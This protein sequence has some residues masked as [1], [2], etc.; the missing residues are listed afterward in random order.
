[1]SDPRGEMLAR[2]RA[3][4]ATARLPAPP[5]LP[6]P[7]AATA[8]VEPLVA[9]FAREASAL[10]CVVHGPIPAGEAEAAVV[11]IL[12]ELHAHRLLA[13][14]AGELPSPGLL[15]ALAEHGFQM[16]DA[17][18]PADRAGRAARLARLDSADVGLTGAL[19]GLADTGSLVL[20]SGP[21]R[22]RLAWLLPP[23]HVALLRVERLFAGLAAFLAGAREQA[24]ANANL[25]FV[26]GPSRTG[27]IELIL[28][29][30]V[31]G[32]GAVHVIL[33]R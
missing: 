17:R 21:G 29:R 28:T 14:E 18:L 7:T 4:L 10:G 19:A 2:V 13:W 23:V 3:A 31:H 16:Q 20:T 5:S 27:D 6:A 24:S 30:G 15:D 12:R 25:V 32:P 9:I 8:S 26:T 11:A 1:M 22:P 33:I